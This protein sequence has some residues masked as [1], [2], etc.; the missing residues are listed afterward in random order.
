MY[1]DLEVSAIDPLIGVRND[2]LAQLMAMLES[3]A[4][5][6]GFASDLIVDGLM[7][8]ITSILARQDV[9]LFTPAID[10]I[11]LSPAKL[12]R[13]IDFIE[14]NLDGEITLADMSAI[15]GLSPFHF[16]RV[17]KLTTGETPYH[18]LCSRRLD[19]ARRLLAKGDMPLAELALACGFA[20]QSHFTA[21]FTKAMG[22]SPGRY[23]RQLFS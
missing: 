9:A 11:R 12:N 22:I 17:F 6:P 10:R 7:R 19:C 13:V 15:A 3:E 20:S 18:Y 4:R 23:R 1:R 21:A 14:A 16:S 2:R 8:A 5:S